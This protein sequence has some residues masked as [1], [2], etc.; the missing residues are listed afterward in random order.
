MS[1]FVSEQ[2]TYPALAW[3]LFLG[4]IHNANLFA[5]P[6]SIVFNSLCYVDPTPKYAAS[7]GAGLLCSSLVC[8]A[9]MKDL[10]RK[11]KWGRAGCVALAGATAKLF[12]PSASEQW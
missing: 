9:P 3:A 4:S 2:L 5:V 10:T 1:P 6:G 12:L 7:A 8:L 11:G